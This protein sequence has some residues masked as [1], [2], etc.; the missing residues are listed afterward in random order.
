MGAGTGPGP[1][2]LPALLVLRI[3]C[4]D[5]RLG[6]AVAA[7]ALIRSSRLH[8]GQTYSASKGSSLFLRALKSAQDWCTQC[9]QRGQNTH[10]SAI[11]SSLRRRS[12]RPRR[13]GGGTG[14]GPDIRA[15]AEEAAAEAL[16]DRLPPCAPCTEADPVV[17]NADAADAAAIVDSAD[18]EDGV[19]DD[20]P[21]ARPPRPRADR[22]PRPLLACSCC[23]FSS[24]AC[25]ACACALRL[26]SV[27]S[28]MPPCRRAITS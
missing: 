18:G 13:P 9:S 21:P 7:A 2:L 15:E 28:S 25:C 12:R 8:M 19:A 16:S 27:C 5:R 14:A 10:G 11:M 22:I 17:E 20:P 3:P 26:C 23:C 4:N 6:G 1:L 24:C